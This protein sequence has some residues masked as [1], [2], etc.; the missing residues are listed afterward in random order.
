M[1]DSTLREITSTRQIPGEPHRLWFSSSKLDLWIWCATDGTP[2]AFQLC[3]DKYQRERALTWQNGRG[4]FHAAVDDGEDEPLRFKQTPVLVTDGSFD[5]TTV[6][7]AFL[8]SSRNVPPHL[9]QFVSGKLAEYA[10]RLHGT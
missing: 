10:N 1:A 3:Y 4:F 6:L 9:V 2:T 8:T 5:A 7:N